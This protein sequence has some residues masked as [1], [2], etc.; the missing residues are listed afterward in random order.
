M[1]FNKFKTMKPMKYIGGA[2]GRSRVRQF[3][4]NPENYT[5]WLYTE[6]VDGEWARIVYDM[7]GEV[8]IQGRGISRATGE[9]KDNTELVPHLVEDIKKNLARGTVLIGEFSFKEYHNFVQREIGS[10][11]RCKAP[12]AIERQKE[13]KLYFH[14]FDCLAFDGI[15]LSEATYEERIK[16]SEKIKTDYILPVVAKRVSKEAIEYLDDILADGGE[17]IMIMNS[18]GKY[19][20]GSR[21]VTVSLKIKK[22]LGELTLPVIGVVDPTRSYEG[23]EASTWPYS[24]DGELVT[25]QYYLGHKAGVIVDYKGNEVKITSGA[26][27]EDRA[28]L[29]TDEAKQMIE[30]GEL[31][32]DATAME[33]FKNVDNDKLSLRHPVL[34]KLRTDL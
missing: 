30:S 1:D 4:A 21:S 19:L 24:I 28:W 33:I 13:N 2:A 9:H 25:K 16:A 7:D 8:T 26:N 31:F 15:D 12:K 11:M 34:L 18:K 32:C 20:P 10:I 3:L 14:S 22:E 6:K 29:A 23:K 5:D 17:G 27:D